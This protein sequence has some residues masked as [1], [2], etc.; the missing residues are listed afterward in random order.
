[1]E[2]HGAALHALTKN[3]QLVVQLK[4][5]YTQANLDDKMRAI[6]DYAVKLTL[7]PHSVKDD[8]VLRLKE[9]GCTDRE[10]LDACQI[11]AYFNFVN[12]MAEGL[13]VEL[14]PEYR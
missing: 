3:E 6:L 12:R 11:T 5:D 4:Q 9:L 14:E 7:H 2:H 8:D 13:G 1:M 10:V